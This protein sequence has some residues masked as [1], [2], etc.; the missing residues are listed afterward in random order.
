MAIYERDIYLGK[1]EG[2]G[3]REGGGERE[4]ERERERESKDGSFTC[5]HLQLMA[6]KRFPHFHASILFSLFIIIF[7]FLVSELPTYSF[8]PLL[9]TS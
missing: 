6:H 2:A 7:Y 1:G 9:S 3:E 4:R 5:N 8:P